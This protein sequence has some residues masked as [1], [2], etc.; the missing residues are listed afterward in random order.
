M[1]YLG[2]VFENVVGITGDISQLLLAVA[3]NP[4]SHAVDPTGSD[5]I[6]AMNG[7]LS[8][9][10]YNPH[11]FPPEQ[12]RAARLRAL[13]SAVG[14]NLFEYLDHPGAFN[15]MDTI[16]QIREIGR[17]A[18]VGFNE[19]SGTAEAMSY[20]N[21]C[22]PSGSQADQFKKY[23]QKAGLFQNTFGPLFEAL[24]PLYRRTDI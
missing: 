7:L 17:L 9:Y 18:K 23:K 10:V 20:L 5:L 24:R 11:L 3:T 16:G 22:P 15:D 13:F 21:K 2:A 4:E 14:A 12:P 8:R 1:D 19:I 6:E